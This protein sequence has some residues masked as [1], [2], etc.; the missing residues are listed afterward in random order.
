MIAKTK[1]ILS[2]QRLELSKLRDAGLYTR[3]H[4]VR[5]GRMWDVI[6]GA[7]MSTEFAI[8]RFLVP[9]LA[10]YRGWAVFCDCDFL[11]RADIAELFTLARPE[12]AVMVVKHFYNPKT[13]LKMDAQINQN[14]PRKNWSSL[15][16]FNCEHPAHR[17][18]SPE[19]VNLMTGRELHSFCWLSDNEI[20]Q[21]PFEWNWLDLEPKAVHMTDG[22]PDMAGHENT[23]YA[24]EWRG[25]LPP[26]GLGL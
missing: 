9:H 23:A 26:G 2:V 14:Y 18:L 15:M 5:D 16:L 11:W 12:Y 22:T 24:D 19:M 10:S 4:E 20:G 17:C 13:A 1:S 3:E 25:H 8:S 7:P 21:L 6:S